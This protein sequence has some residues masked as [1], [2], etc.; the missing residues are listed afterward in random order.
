MH[1]KFRKHPGFR[2]ATTLAPIFSNLFHEV[3]N[4]P[5]Q[6]VIKDQEKKYAT[7]AANIV[8]YADKYEISIALPGFQKEQIGIHLENNQLIIAT[9]KENGDT[10]GKA[11]YREFFAHNFKRSFTLTDKVNKETIHAS[12][13]NGIL[14]V[15]IQKAEEAKPKTISIL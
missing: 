10:I 12:Y 13:A 5:V 7:P 9:E 6:D 1:T 14:V 8:E 2:T 15:S 4:A 11:I 3:M